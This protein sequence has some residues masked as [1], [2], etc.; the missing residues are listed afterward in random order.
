L[1]LTILKKRLLPILAVALTLIFLGIL[2][3]ACISASENSNVFTFSDTSINAASEG[4]G[5]EIDRTTLTIN[6]AGTYT[7][8]GSCAE[9]SV[10][11]KKEVIGVTLVL[12]SLTLTSSETAPISCNKSSSVTIEA[13]GESTLTNTEDASTEEASDT[14]EGAAIKVKSGASLS[15]T[16][17]G[18][19]NIEGTCKNG[20]KGGVGA[21]VTVSDLTLNV[22]AADNAL[23]SDG[24][25]VVNS[26]ILTL[27]A[28]NDGLKSAPDADD[29]ESDGT[30]IINGG[31]FAITSNGDGIQGASAL[32]INSGDLTVTAGGG[33]EAELAEDASAKGL[34]SDG[35][36]TIN[37]G[38]FNLDCADDTL[39]AANVTLAAGTYTLSSGDDGVHADEALVVGVQDAENGPNITVT[40]SYEGLEGATVTLYSGSGSITSSDDG[41]NAANGDLDSSYGFTLDIYGGSW[42]VNADGDALDSNGDVNFHGGVTEFY[43]SANN[44][45][46]ALDYNDS[47]T[48]DG[49]TFLAVGASGMAQT[50][51]TG[52]YVAFGASG[53]G[54][55][56]GGQRPDQTTDGST[57]TDGTSAG[58][59]TPPDGTQG[60]PPSMDGQQPTAPADNSTLEASNGTTRGGHGQR[61]DMGG[62]MMNGTVD[63]STSEFVIAEGSAIVIKDSD[64]NTLYSATGVKAANSVVFGA[65]TLVEGETY[66]LYIDGVEAATATAET[67]TGATQGFGSGMGGQR[68]DGTAGTQSSTADS[69]ENAPAQSSAA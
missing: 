65:E 39:H 46:A 1:T 20:I 5:Y 9:G 26:G 32:T 7:L 13:R 36:L 44:G 55:G 61:G 58:G 69:S 35:T 45:N 8:T 59:M 17:S 67:G 6:A 51:S 14:F 30:V 43:G 15:L 31:T 53:M 19:L 16:G 27:T 49:G 64:G 41:I 3:P 37:G 66:T 54:S 29:T 22:T 38:S 21:S 42:Y 57:S 63:A 24:S 50:P 25:V 60:T 40:T 4:S 56:M 18:T 12:D 28:G 47:C 62:G 34:K 48:Y 33:C 2:L 10:T 52:T 11:V 68:P 23:S